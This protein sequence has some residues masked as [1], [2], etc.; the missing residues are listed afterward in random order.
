MET[1]VDCS[2]RLRVATSELGQRAAALVVGLLTAAASATAAAQASPHTGAGLARGLST[3]DSLISAAVEHTIPGAVLVVA[4]NGTVLEERAFGWAELNDFHVHRLAG[5]RPMHTSTMFDLASVTKVMATTMAVMM[6]ASDGRIDVDATVHRYLP[7]FRGAHLDSITVRH[8]LTHSAGLVQWQRLYYHASNERQ[9]YDVIRRMPTQWGIGEARHYSDLGFMLLGYIVEHVTGRPLDRYLAESLYTPLGLHATTYVP[10]QHGF[11]DFAATEQGNGYERHMVYDSTF[12]YRYRGDPTAWNGWREYVLNG[13]TD[14][15]NSWYAH[16]GVAGHAGLFSTAADLRVLLDLLLGHGSYGGRQFI[17]PEIV[18]RFLTRDKYQNFLGWMSPNG[19]PEGSFSHNGFTGTS[20]LGV[21]KYDLSIVLLTNRQNM[22]TDARGY[23]PNVGPL[24]SLVAR[25]IVTGAELDARPPALDTPDS[26]FVRENYTKQEYRIPMRDGVHLF[27]SVYVPKD[28]SPAN[29]YPIVLQRTCYSVAPYGPEAYPFRVGPDRF[30]MHEK[31]IFVYQDVRGRYM[32]E[33]AFVNA[34]PFIADS[35]KAR[36]PKA[37]DEAS[38]AY[39]TIDWL[40]H[41]VA[42]NNGRV[43][44]WG[45]SYPGFY[46]SMG[47]LSRHPAL[48]A[49]SPQAPVTD[50][51]FEDFHHNGALTQ[52]YFYAYPVFGIPSPGPTTENWW[53]PEFEK[54]FA[55]GLPDD[56]FYQLSLG[57]LTNTTERF[58]KGNTL[59]QEIIAHPNY[60][61]FWQARAVLPGL[62]GVKHAVMAVGGWFDAEDLYGPLAVYKTLRKYDGEAK[63]SIV[64]GPFRHGGWAAP[65]MVHTVHG[66]IY[67]G[68]SLETKFQRDVEAPFFRAYLK[69]DGRTDLPEALMF[70]TGSKEWERFD[71]W[72]APAATTREYYFH[73]DGSLTT[74]KPIEARAS[75]EYPSDPQKPVPSRCVEPTIEGGSLYHYM[76]DDQRCFTS[77]PDVLVFQTDT[78]RADVTFGGEITAKLMVSTTGTDA[79]FVVKLIDVYPPEMPDSPYQPDK[80]VHLAGYQQLV[81]GEIMRGRF[82]HSFVVPE[83]FQANRLTDV[84]FRLQ[85]VLHTFKKGHRIMVQVQSSWFPVFDRNPQTYVPNIYKANAADFIKA[86]ERVFVDRAAASG[87]EVQVL[88]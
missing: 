62:R 15:G 61:A 13:E 70:N 78:L 73:A 43:G 63:A 34:R 56:Y 2:R 18:D 1:P 32:S 26:V 25:A 23:F 49:S 9:T 28:A 71:R 67:F 55:H 59:W 11:S 53:M 66:D 88:P 87:I 51:F 14:D 27:T 83:A 42:A 20:V 30:M 36:D 75:L 47:A 40:L 80:N 31:Y 45:I 46:V 54:I 29:R 85:D 35:I 69:G 50:F 77:R 44:Q 37:V 38:D 57:P 82:R 84:S 81:R 76:S 10:K 39:D 22:G 52:A 5:P 4:Q 41:N 48:V 58:Y 3:A 12:G 6:L 68:D 19:L 65:N 60:D 17:R 24:D 8:L 33:G 64:M 79:D 21:P 72:P 7:D 74:S 16:R 86:T